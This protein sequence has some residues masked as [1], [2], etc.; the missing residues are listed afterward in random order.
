MGH[1]ILVGESPSHHSRSLTSW[2]VIE[3]Q[4]FSVAGHKL[5]NANQRHEHSRQSHPV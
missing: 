1:V 3:P 4:E 5:H 2:M